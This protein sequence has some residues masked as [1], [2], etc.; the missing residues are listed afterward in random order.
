MVTS[1]PSLYNALANLTSNVLIKITTDVTLSSIISLADLTNITITGHNNPTVNCNSSGGLQL[2]SCHNCIIEGISWDNCGGK[3]IRENISRPVLKVINSSNITIKDCLFQQSIGQAIVL[4]RMTGDVTISHC[5]FSSNNHYEG[6]GSAIYYSS[7]DTSKSSI[8]FII[9][10]SNFIHN[11]GARSVV[12]LDQSSESAK[13]CEYLFLQNSNF[14]YNKAVPIYLSNQNLYI[15]GDIK[16]NGNVADNGGGIYIS[17]HSNVTVYK[18]ATVK[19]THNRAN[20]NGGAIF[21]TNNSNIIFKENHILQQYYDKL[22]YTVGDQYPTRSLIVAFYN[23]TANKFGGNIY[24][25][26]SKIMF[27]DDADI[28]FDGISC[29]LL[30]HLPYKNSERSIVHTS[31]QSIMLFGGNSRVTFNNYCIYNDDKVVMF[32]D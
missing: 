27:D 13:S 10:N 20:R 22:Y 5:N 4:S 26:N 32:I 3:N 2:I 25:Y 19:F 23:N 16:F 17:D 21:L 11:E 15:S 29:H 6:H 1:C 14:Y 24:V 12:Y 18:N 7:N 28:K 9:V 30:N 31:D 8:T